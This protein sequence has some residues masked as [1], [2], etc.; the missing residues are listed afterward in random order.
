[1]Q[2]TLRALY[3]RVLSCGRRRV[4][5]TTPRA[6]AVKAVTMESYE[7]FR[8]EKKK[9]RS[10]D[11]LWEETYTDNVGADGTHSVSIYRNRSSGDHFLSVTK[12]VLFRLHKHSPFDTVFEL[13]VRNEF[14]HYTSIIP[15][16][17]SFSFLEWIRCTSS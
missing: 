4:K 2:I 16:K 11:R 12:S 13:C 5:Y 10:Y 15:F 1:M 17:Y 6:G 9:Q 3:P 7:N 8:K 14:K